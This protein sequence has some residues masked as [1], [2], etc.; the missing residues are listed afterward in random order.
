MRGEKDVGP[1]GVPTGG[2]FRATAPIIC[3]YV[4]V[5]DRIHESYDFFCGQHRSLSV[6][7]RSKKSRNGFVGEA[8]RQ[9]RN[10]LLIKIRIKT[11]TL[12]RN[13]CH[14]ILWTRRLRA[15][16][17][18]ARSSIPKGDFNSFRGFVVR[19]PLKSVFYKRSKIEEDGGFWFLWTL[20]FSA[21]SHVK[22]DFSTEFVEKVPS[23]IRI[24]LISIVFF[25]LIKRW[26]TILSKWARNSSTLFT[27][28]ITR[29]FRTGR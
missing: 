5:K 9:I 29:Y 8:W 23:V 18:K 3:L 17:W 28:S 14:R 21:F 6:H 15:K 26:A 16:F 24:P 25:D 13:T 10:S 20:R 7:Y 1:A 19:I 12:R 22:K 11:T 27:E 4:P 2:I